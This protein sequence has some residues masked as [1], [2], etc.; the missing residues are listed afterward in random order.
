MATLKQKKAI[1]EIVEN[2]GNVSQGMIKAGYSKKSAKNPKNLTESKAWDELMDTYLSDQ[3]LSEKHQALLN[4]TGIAHQVYPLN[5]T[6]EQITELLKEANCQVKRFMHSEFQ[7]HVW[8]FAPDNRARKDALD[9]A[10]KLKGRYAES[11][12][13]VKP[14][15]INFISFN[16]TNRDN[17]SLPLHSEELPA[18]VS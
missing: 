6:D 2:R 7:T 18:S 8:Y 9:M 10:Y 14:V 12:D 1:E 3:E 16:A 4:A 13:S 17:N 11:P 15:T 5:V